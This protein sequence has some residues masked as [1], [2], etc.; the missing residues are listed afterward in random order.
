M[1]P[2]RLLVVDDEVMWSRSCGG[3]WKRRHTKFS[4][5]TTSVKRYELFAQDQPDL[6]ITDLR[7]PAMDGFEL[8]RHIR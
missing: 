2:I 3:G 5:T 1:S 4:G 7:M 8:I 6:T